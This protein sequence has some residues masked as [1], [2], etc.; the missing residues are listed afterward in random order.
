MI[1]TIIPI[2][3]L[4]QGGNSFAGQ[5]GLTIRSMSG[6]KIYPRFSLRSVEATNSKFFCAASDNELGLFYN[7]SFC[8]DHYSN[9]IV[10]SAELKSKE[11]LVV[12][13][14]SAPVI[15]IDD[16]TSELVEFSGRWIGELQTTQV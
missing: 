11:P 14:F 12:D 15:P 8:V 13:W 1:D 5:A 7:A 10:S 6:S 2:D 3:I 9:V 4:P 16:Y